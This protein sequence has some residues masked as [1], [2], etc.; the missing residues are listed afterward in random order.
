M[1]IFGLQKTRR[2]GFFHFESAKKLFRLGL[3]IRHMLAGDGIEF[4][5]LHFFQHDFFVFAGGVE[6]DI[7]IPWDTMLYAHTD[8]RDLSRPDQRA[9]RS[10]G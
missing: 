6:F 8:D 1:L 7:C 5:D 2:S 9:E 10:R 4:A 3:F